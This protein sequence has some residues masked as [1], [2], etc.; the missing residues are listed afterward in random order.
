MGFLSSHDLF[1]WIEAEAIVPELS[2]GND[3]QP[4]M[5]LCFYGM[6]VVYGIMQAIIVM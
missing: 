3:V 6:F 5:N 1:S 2:E 4:V